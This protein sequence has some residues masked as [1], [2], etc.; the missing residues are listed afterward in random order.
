MALVLTAVLVIGG[1]V[2]EQIWAG[3]VGSVMAGEG[4]VVLSR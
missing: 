1:F 3:V 4:S 2:G